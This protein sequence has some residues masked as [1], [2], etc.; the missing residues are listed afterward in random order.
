MTSPYK[1]VHII[2]NPASGQDE[3]ILN[4]LNSVFH[5]TD[6]EWEISLTKKFGD[7][8][9]FAK[10]AVERGVDL[11]A[12]YGG[13]GTQMEVANGLLGSSV[14]QAILPG[15]TGNAMAYQLK[16]P[17]DL[18]QATQLIVDS[19]KRKAID[20]AR[21]G[22]KIFMLRTYT[23]LDAE[24]AASREMKDKFGQLAY[25]AASMQFLLAKKGA[26]YKATVDGEVIE[27]EATICFILNAGALGGVLN[28]PLPDVPDVDVSDG[29]LDLYAITHGIKPIRAVS[30]FVFHA[31]VGNEKVGIYH[32]QGREIT[33]EADPPQS[34]WIDGEAYGE[35]PITAISLPKALE[36]VVPEIESQNNQTARKF[37]HK[38]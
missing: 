34:V 21:I 30:Q 16:V 36:I 11:V 22:E 4:V 24:E 29:M 3:P 19:P 6:I 13:D 32:W 18:R 1:R 9:R 35:T 27:G 12:A 20:L 5:P 37:T 8:T 28:I 26:H 23:G 7:A 10:E 14:P 31:D 38:R 15:G 17:R 25:V 33:I 2:I